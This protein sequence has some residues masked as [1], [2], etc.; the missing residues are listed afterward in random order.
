MIDL[1]S[2]MGY[3]QNSPFSNSPYLDIKTPEGLITMENTPIDLL[4]IDNY[5]NIKKMKA[6]KKVPYKFSGNLVREIPMKMGGNPYQN[7]GVTN[8]QLFDYL[9]NDDE[10]ESMQIAPEPEDVDDSKDLSL[11]KTERLI[12]QREEEGL[13]MEAAM[14]SFDNPYRRGGDDTFFEDEFSTDVDYNPKD[15]NL[16]SSHLPKRN[17]ANPGFR[18]FSTYAEGRNA[19]ENQLKLYQTGKTKNPVSPNSSLLHAMSVYAPKGDGNNNPVVYANFIAQRLGISPNTPISKINT[20]Q[21][22]DAIEKMEGNKH[23]NNPGNLRR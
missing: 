12:R 7:G 2:I 3:S 21:W 9:F 23:G 13:A 11:A 14:M 6:G 19:L 4:G 8:Q 10:E 1:K 15:M 22:A 16:Y 18:T 17:S 20:K 5:G